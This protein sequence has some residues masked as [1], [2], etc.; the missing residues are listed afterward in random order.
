MKQIKKPLLGL[1]L[2][3]FGF[4]QLHAANWLALQGYQPKMVAPKGVYVPYRRKTPVLW[5]FIQANYKKDQGTV[6]YNG[7]NQTTTPFS[8][9]NPD[10]KSQEGF[11]AF[12]LRLALRGMADNENKVNYFFMTETGNNGIN[13]L[14]GHREIATYFSDASVT[15]KHIPGMK[16]RVGMFKTPGSEEGLQAVFVS[17]YIEFTN[18]SFQQ[19]LERQIKSVGSELPANKSGGAATDHYNGDPSG[20]IAAFRDTGLQLFDTF[21]F[22]KH[23]EASYAYMIGNGSGI[24]M[25]SSLEN[26]THYA[27]T[28]LEYLFHKGRGYFTES[29]KAFAWW[30][31]GNRRL[32]INSTTPQDFTRTRSGLGLTYYHNGLRFETEYFNAAGMIYEGAKDT[33]TSSQA[34][35]NWTFQYAVGSEN[36]A[37]GYYVN[38]EYELLPKKLEIYGRYDYMDRLSNDVKGQRLFNTTIIGTT[39]RFKGATR[40]D[41]N[42]IMRKATAPGNASAQTVLDNMGNRIAVQVTAHF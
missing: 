6:A 9:L 39:Y 8:L 34:V 7:S 41:F 20:P 27:Y 5:G 42:Y 3:S 17:P 26:K 31:S 29:I 28:S 1:L 25:S 36:K 11:N 37:S 12:R 16:I 24:S 22:G 2:A 40:V 18:F 10:L 33:D 35:Q 13:N 23:I 38:L 15:I 32:L 4:S 21:K 14:A 19:L 30:Q